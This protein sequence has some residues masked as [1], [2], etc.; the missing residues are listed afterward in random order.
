MYS[1]FCRVFCS[2]AKMNEY[3]LMDILVDN[4]GS[5]SKYNWQRVLTSGRRDW[6]SFSFNCLLIGVES[7]EN[8]D[9]GNFLLAWYRKSWWG[10]D[11]SACNEDDMHIKQT[12]DPFHYLSV[13]IYSHL[14]IHLS[15]HLSIYISIYNIPSLRIPVES[16]YNVWLK[17]PVQTLSIK[18]ISN[19]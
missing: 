15:F 8:S 3:E 1:L 4:I 11:S 18:Y 14:S 5:W 16:H 9:E 19:I 13:H 17:L 12:I 2:N 7:G 6:C 10:T